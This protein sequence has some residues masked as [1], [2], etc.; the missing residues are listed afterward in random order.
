MGPESVNH[1]GKLAETRSAGAGS[2]C[3]MMEREHRGGGGL[4][5]PLHQR[6]EAPRPQQPLLLPFF[7]PYG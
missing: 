1:E 5:V 4:V 2:Q 7:P 3:N 6:Q